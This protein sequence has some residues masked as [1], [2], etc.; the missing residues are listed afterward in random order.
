MTGR[1]RVEKEPVVAMMAPRNPPPPQVT[2][3]SASTEFGNSERAMHGPSTSFTLQAAQK[4]GEWG[5]AAD[6][7][8]KLPVAEWLQTNSQ[9]ATF[10]ANWVLTRTSDSVVTALSQNESL[11]RAEYR[12]FVAAERLQ[13]FY[14]PD[15][16]SDIT[17][18]AGKLAG[19][20]DA[21]LAGSRARVR[22]AQPVAAGRAAA[23]LR[24]RGPTP[25]VHY[26]FTRA[27]RPA[28][29]QVAGPRRVCVGDRVQLSSSYQSQ[30]D[31][32]DGPLKPGDEGVVVKDDGPDDPKPYLVQPDGGGRTWWY[33]EA[34]LR[35][36]G[37][38]D[39][40]GRS[41]RGTVDPALAGAPAYDEVAA[42]AGY[43]NDEERPMAARAGPW[44][45]G[46]MYCGLSGFRC[47]AGCQGC[48]PTNG[49][50]CPSCA[51][52]AVARGER[53]FVSHGVEAALEVTQSVAQPGVVYTCG[54][55]VLVVSG[56]AVWAWTAEGIAL[57]LSEAS[58][59]WLDVCDGA[60]S[61]TVWSSGVGDRRVAPVTRAGNSG[62]EG[63]NSAAAGQPCVPG[64]GAVGSTLVCA[65]GKW[66]ITR[67]QANEVRLQL[68]GEDSYFTLS[69]SPWRGK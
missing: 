47:G 8:S 1:A 17:P 49:C 26:S 66:V 42:A 63:V 14:G 41:L 38:A 59:G 12:F 15:L 48:G 30:G 35:A 37:G 23:C 62:W 52:W 25:A 16:V 53:Y 60:D 27:P 20:P 45:T 51:R 57:W 58:N 54:V 61:F 21:P 64:L 6:S 31:A 68:R 11:P 29:P 39:G 7:F 40:G 44:S 19:A 69:V 4:C 65:S 32:D 10:A 67:R 36:A 50:Q 34:A 28:A 9:S 46:M 18:R 22:G 43:V 55:W 24:L 13:H 5:T 2:E 3:W 56:D 33:R